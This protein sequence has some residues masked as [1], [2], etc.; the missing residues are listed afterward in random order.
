M[1]KK[2]DLIEKILRIELEMFLAVSSFEKARCQESPGAFKLVRGSVFEVWSEDTLGAY[3]KDLAE[4]VNAG[5]NL[6]AEK[7]ARMDNLIPCLSLNSKIDDILEIEVEWQ[8]SVQRKY[9]HMLSGS[10]ATGHCTAN[11]D[12]Y[13]RCELETYSDKT[14][15]SYFGDILRA[16]EEGKNLADEKNTRIFQKLG[17]KSLKQAEEDFRKKAGPDRREGKDEE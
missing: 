11:F 15:E 14:I 16:K 10:P 2:S 12:V 13:L 17:Y 6:M 4:A 5:R 3:L 1:S 8:K 9:P 7:Y